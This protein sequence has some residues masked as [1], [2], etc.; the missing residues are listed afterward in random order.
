MSCLYVF[1]FIIMDYEKIRDAILDF[2]EK[3]DWKQFHNPKDLAT[4]IA[5]EAAELQEVF[6][7]KSQQDSYEIGKNDPHVKEEF[8]DIFNFMVLFAEECWIDIEKEVLA[9][10]EKN[11][12]KYSVDKAKGKSDKYDKL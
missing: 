3:R 12:Q 8:S 7:W 4:A 10:L 6:L 11:G 2:R 5:I 9:K 1:I